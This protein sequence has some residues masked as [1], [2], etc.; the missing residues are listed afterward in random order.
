MVI[1]SHFTLPPSI[2]DLFSSYPGDNTPF[3]LSFLASTDPNTGKPWCPDVEAALPR[4]NEI[5]SDS[6]G[7][8]CGYVYVGQKDAWKDHSNVFRTKWGVR[9]VPTLVRYE[10]VGGEVR[11]IGRLE[12]GEILDLERLKGF[13]FGESTAA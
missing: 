3:F 10:V 1:L 13:V 9:C 6:R 12:E 5:F 7:R 11:E 4:L 2:S 8:S